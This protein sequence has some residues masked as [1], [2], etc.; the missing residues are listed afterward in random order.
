MRRLSKLGFGL[1]LAGAG[2]LMSAWVF[3][4]ED[5][6]RTFGAA[7]DSIVGTTAA[8]AEAD[9]DQDTRHYRRSNR[10]PNVMSIFLAPRPSRRTRCG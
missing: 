3:A 7:V 5:R 4:P 1:A 6:L 9:P 10:S 2:A 8:H